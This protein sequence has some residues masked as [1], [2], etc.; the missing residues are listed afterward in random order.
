M[1]FVAHRVDARLAWGVFGS[2]T[3]VGSTLR[4]LALAQSPGAPGGPLEPYVLRF[5]R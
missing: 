2:F 4:R 5:D 1:N 3:R